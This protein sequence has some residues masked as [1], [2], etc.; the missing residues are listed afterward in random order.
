MS[1]TTISYRPPHLPEGIDIDEAVSALVDAG[2]SERQA[3]ALAASDTGLKTT[4]IQA[5]FGHANPRITGNLIVAGKRA[6]GREGEV[7]ASASGRGSRT[8][9]RDPKQLISD[10]LDRA[11]AALDA[12]TRPVA[13]AQ[14]AL[15]ALSTD[16][17]VKAFTA[18]RITDLGERVK[19]LQAEIKALKDDPAPAVEA[20]R[21]RLTNRL[22]AAQKAAD[23]NAERLRGAVEELEGTLALLAK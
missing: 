23:E 20:E 14:A 9:V 22:T 12:A 2:A 3:W 19:A 11:R 10:E 5:W 18:A 16:D 1:T 21:E 13:D 8:P 17:G 6:V 4:D 7:Q 15:D